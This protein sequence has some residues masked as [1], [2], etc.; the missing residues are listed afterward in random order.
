[1]HL[2]ISNKMLYICN[3]AFSTYLVFLY[4]MFVY[5]DAFAFSIVIY[6]LTVMN[7]FD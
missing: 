4:H 2:H 6:V 3:E 5:M 1:M 7:I